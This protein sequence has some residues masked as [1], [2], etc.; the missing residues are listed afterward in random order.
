MCFHAVCTVALMVNC[1]TFQCSVKKKAQKKNN[2]GNKHTSLGLKDMFVLRKVPT[3][4]V[5]SLNMF[6]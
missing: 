1:N 6:S 4:N 3:S 5:T 2:L